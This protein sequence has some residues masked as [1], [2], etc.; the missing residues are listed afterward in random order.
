[1]TDKAMFPGKKCGCHWTTEYGFVPEADCP[2]HD[3]PEFQEFM[4]FFH[5]GEKFPDHE[6]GGCGCG[7]A[8]KSEEQ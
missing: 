8:T 7:G 5:A 3:S 1:M 4:A 2:E 6:W